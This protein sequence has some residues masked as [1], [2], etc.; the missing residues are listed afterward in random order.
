MGVVGRLGQAPGERRARLFCRLRRGSVWRLAL[1]VRRL[2][3]FKIYIQYLYMLLYILDMKD[4]TE[5]EAF[6]RWKGLRN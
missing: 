3:L 2:A 1:G 5:F 6:H 4:F